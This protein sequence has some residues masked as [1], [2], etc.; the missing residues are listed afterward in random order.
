ML[1][2]LRTLSTGGKT[3]K[4]ALSFFRGTPFANGLDDI[5][6]RELVK[7]F[8][9]R[10]YKE[11]EKLFDARGALP[12]EVVVVRTGQLI[13]VDDE[14]SQKLN[15][16]FID[17]MV[18]VTASSP[19][20]SP[21]KRMSISASSR[22]AANLAMGVGKTKRM[23]VTSISS[24]SLINTAPVKEIIDSLE[25]YHTNYEPNDILNLPGR[26]KPFAY[27]IHASKATE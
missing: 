10:E 5:Q 15:A 6:L 16:A 17:M 2:S 1:N 24:N 14:N 4:D 11:G 25:G 7:L 3:K 26:S 20:P 18:A 22:D 9:T 8:K 12:T 19:R 13:E 21:M 23:S 27:A